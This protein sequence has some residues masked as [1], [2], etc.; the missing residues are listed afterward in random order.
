M[1]PID[2]IYAKQFD[3]VARC[4][5]ISKAKIG[6]EEDNYIVN[7]WDAGAQLANDGKID[8]NKD[9]AWSDNVFK[10]AKEVFA[11]RGLSMKA[12]FV[13]PRTGGV[14]V[15]K[16]FGENGLDK[17]PSDR[18]DYWRGI[19]G[20]KDDVEFRQ[21][22]KVAPGFA[23]FTAERVGTKGGRNDLGLAGYTKDVHAA[24]II[25]ESPLAVATADRPDLE[26]IGFNISEEVG[27]AANPIAVQRVTFDEAYVKERGGTEVS[28]EVEG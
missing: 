23:Y 1:I 16:W 27:L 28:W 6:G 4:L 15:L 22:R 17:L 19:I 18:K 2:T 26:H 20:W 12:C 10:K 14:E 21:T 11:K 7:L 8:G 9:I 3:L 13:N 5:N 25:E 24:Y